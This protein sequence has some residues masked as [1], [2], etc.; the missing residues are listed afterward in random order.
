M[1]RRVRRRRSTVLLTALLAAV[2]TVGWV[3]GVGPPGAA[4][5]PATGCLPSGEALTGTPWATSMLVPERVWPHS[6]GTGQRVAVVSTGVDRHPRLPRPVATV[7]VSP[8]DP[9]RRQPSGRSDCLGIGTGVA[10]LIAGRP[11]P[12]DPFAGLAP[13]VTLLSA[14]VVGDQYP[15]DQ[16]ARGAVD[17]NVLAKAIDWAVDRDAD[18]IVV[19]EVALVGS[20]TLAGAV[21]RAVAAD[22]VVVAAVGEPSGVDG[23]AAEQPTFPA[24]LP[25]VVGVGVLTPTGSAEVSRPAHVDLVAPGLD[26]VVP[27]PRG[28]WGPAAG[29]GFAA[30]Y[31]AGAAALVR[32]RYPDLSA[33]EVTRRLLATAAPAPEGVGSPRYGYGIVDP[34][35]AVVQQLAAGPPVPVPAYTTPPVDP[36]ARAQEQERQ[37]GHTLALRL[38]G[39]GVALAVLLAA[40]VGFGPRGHRRRWRAG[41]APVPMDRPDATHPEPPMPLFPERRQPH[42]SR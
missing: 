7:D 28:G 4:Q 6:D 2:A 13:G 42:G 23:Q 33:A 22:T 26:L 27:Y 18:V 15:T 24:A 8:V 20:D 19:T 37:R 39:V 34:Y 21:D 9:H 31:V 41:L 14:K 16:P 5:P 30:G 25:E 36:E 32:A 12:D 40:V 10:G 17:P 11:A 1:S 3:T 29:S 38:A 35:Q